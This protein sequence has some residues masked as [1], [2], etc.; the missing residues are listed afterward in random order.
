MNRIGKTIEKTEL[1]DVYECEKC[2]Y[3]SIE[4]KDCPRCL[5]IKYHEEEMEVRLL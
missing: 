5:K 4:N 1:I 3:R 2:K